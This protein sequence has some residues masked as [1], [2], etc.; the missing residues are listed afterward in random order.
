MK[1]RKS[2]WGGLS[3][4]TTILVVFFVVAFLVTGGGVAVH[5]ARKHH[6]YQ[7]LPRPYPATRMNFG[8]PDWPVK[9]GGDILNFDSLISYV[10]LPVDLPISL[11]TDTVLLPLDLY[12]WR[13]Q[14][15]NMEYVSNALYSANMPTADEFKRHY[16]P[17]YSLYVVHN[18]L[19]QPPEKV[20]QELLGMLFD[21]GVSSSLLCSS[22]RLDEDFARRLADRILTEANSTESLLLLVQNKNLSDDTLRRLA[23]LNNEHLLPFVAGHERA[24]PD[25]LRNLAR[26]PSLA[27]PIARNRSAPPDVLSGLADNP[28]NV[29]LLVQNNSTTPD[30]LLK[31]LP[32]V[33]VSRL[34][35]IVGHPN[36]NEAV[37]DAMIDLGNRVFDRGF[38]NG[39]ERYWYDL[40]LATVANKALPKDR[41]LAL[42]AMPSPT[43]LG[44]LACN[45][46][47]DSNIL[48]TILT[49]CSHVNTNDSHSYYFKQATDYAQGYLRQLSKS[50]TKK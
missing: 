25:L 1:G 5:K 8:N 28:K 39:D 4:W 14:V 20:S 2:L 26:N 50:K 36:A 33:P 48:N 7:E 21:A 11:V 13:Q 27:E 41:L 6:K 10:I 46:N 40:A 31:M 37:C 32:T 19:C 44:M 35:T 15:V 49:T 43:M 9:E 34:N 38:F 16:T 24:S 23:G 47:A 42:A 3:R 12:R 30:V 17:T 22:S 29:D 45:R 18:Y